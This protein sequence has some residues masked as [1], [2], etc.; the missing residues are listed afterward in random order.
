M[1][2]AI[3]SL[4]SVAFGYDPALKPSSD[5][6]YQPKDLLRIEVTSVEAECNAKPF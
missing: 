6:P 5:R 1:E 2:S 4:P 3:L